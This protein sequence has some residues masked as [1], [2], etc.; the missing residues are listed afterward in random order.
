MPIKNINAKTLEKWLENDEA[1]V[2]DVREPSEY[3]A[4][5]IKGSKLI[6]LAKICKNNLPEYKNKKLV[7][8]C[9]GG[10]RSENACKKLLTEDEN[11][12]LYNLEGGISAWMNIGND[13]NSSGKF[14]LPLDRQVQL[15]IGLFVLSG[16]CFGYFVN[17]LYF[18]VPAFF[19]S[20]LVFAGL[21]GNCAFASLIAKMP[22]NNKVKSGNTSCC[23]VE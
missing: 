21:T 7:L 4:N 17:P 6:P 14:F 1:I 2:V 9:Q 15:T 19:G 10:R 8:H 23:K 3:E 11:L 5:R 22:W 12:E 13:V 20:G 16:S 18:I